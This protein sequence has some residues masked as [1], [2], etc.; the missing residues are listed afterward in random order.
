MPS[1]LGRG[2]HGHAHWKGNKNRT[3]RRGR[4]AACGFG[5]QEA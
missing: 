5:F 1:C 3:S 2:F 4:K